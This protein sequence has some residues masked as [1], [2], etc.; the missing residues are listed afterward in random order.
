MIV[1]EGDLDKIDMT[2]KEYKYYIDLFIRNES[3]IQLVKDGKGKYDIYI[4]QAFVHDEQRRLSGLTIIRDKDGNA[5]I[6]DRMGN[7]SYKENI[8]GERIE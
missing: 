2:E 6:Y 3:L 7:L 5:S 8:M 4:D 1:H